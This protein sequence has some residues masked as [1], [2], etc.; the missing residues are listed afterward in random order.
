MLWQLIR[1]KKF[2]YPL[3]DP[4]PELLSAIRGEAALILVIF[5]MEELFESILARG[6]GMFKV[7][8]PKPPCMTNGLDSMFMGAR[9]WAPVTGVWSWFSTCVCDDAWDWKPTIWLLPPLLLLLPLHDPEDNDTEF[10]VETDNGGI[11]MFKDTG[12]D[13]T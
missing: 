7:V 3:Y 11:P 5:M 12:E 9:I 13:G 1:R 2:T 6:W 10:V 4:T 8:P